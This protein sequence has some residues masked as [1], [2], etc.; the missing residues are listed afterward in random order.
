MVEVLLQRA[1]AVMSCT[2]Y[3]RDEFFAHNWLMKRAP[4]TNGTV[5]SFVTLDAHPC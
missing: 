4:S 3:E 2:I 1:L 5:I